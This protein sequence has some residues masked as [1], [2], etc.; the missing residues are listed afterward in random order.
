M[1]SFVH[2]T[3][4]KAVC[5]NP[6]VFFDD[7]H[8]FSVL[9]WAL[10]LHY[11]LLPGTLWKC[12]TLVHSVLFGTGVLFCNLF[13]AE[14]ARYQSTCCYPSQ[15]PSDAEYAIGGSCAD[16]DSI[17]SQYAASNSDQCQSV[18]TA[19]LLGA[20]YL[21]LWLGCWTLAILI[22]II[23]YH[24]YKKLLSDRL[25][26]DPNPEYII[27]IAY[28][29]FIDVCFVFGVQ[30]HALNKKA[31]FY[32]R[33]VC[34]LLAIIFGVLWSIVGATGPAWN[35]YDDSSD[36]ESLTD[37]MC[38]VPGTPAFEAWA[39]EPGH[40]HPMDVQVFVPALFM[41]FASIYIGIYAVRI[42]GVPFYGY[43]WFSTVRWIGARVK[44]NGPWLINPYSI[45]F[46]HKW[47]LYHSELTRLKSFL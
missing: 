38:N 29:M 11:L 36:L 37:G 47:R 18:V 30:E 39:Y 41:V 15:R 19:T 17:I 27:L 20:L 7:V 33:L 40:F 14:N 45:D 46:I 21:G 8:N 34:G 23:T 9:S 16:T 24:E 2:R 3:H 35:C 26:H 31:L 28:I 42:F 10:G 5:I 22:Y 4:E 32:I 43:E 1:I 6:L 44:R 13:F 12:L 25:Q